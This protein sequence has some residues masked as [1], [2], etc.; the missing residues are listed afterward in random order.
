MSRKSTSKGNCTNGIKYVKLHKVLIQHYHDISANVRIVATLL[1]LNINK[2]VSLTLY[3]REIQ[4][5]NKGA[6]SIKI[7]QQVT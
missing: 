1:P 6:N 5:Y 4:H 2:Y 7:A 3:L